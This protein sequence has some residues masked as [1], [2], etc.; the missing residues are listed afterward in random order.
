AERGANGDVDHACLR[1]AVGDA[2]ELGTH[3]RDLRRAGAEP[4]SARV[5]AVVVHEQHVDLGAAQRV[6]HG[7]GTVGGEIVLSLL[8]VVATQQRHGVR[9]HRVGHGPPDVA[10]ERVVAPVGGARPGHPDDAFGQLPRQLV[11]HELHGALVA[12]QRHQL[13]AHAQHD[14]GHHVDRLLGVV[15]PRLLDALTVV[16]L[17]PPARLRLVHRPVVVRGAGLTCD[18][19]PARDGEDVRPRAI[20]EHDDEGRPRL[21]PRDERCQRR[22][23]CPPRQVVLLWF[24]SVLEQLH[25][26]LGGDDAEHVAVEMGVGD[27]GLD[28]IEHAVGRALRGER[29]AHGLPVLD[30]PRPRV[31]HRG[32]RVDDDRGER[33]R[34]RDDVDE[35]VVADADVRDGAGS[36]HA[37]PPT[38]DRARAFG[39]G[40]VVTGPYPCG[41]AASRYLDA[42]NDR[43]VI[44]DGAFG[45]YMQA[46]GLTADDF[47]GPELEGCT[48]NLVLT[49]PD[50]IA[51]MH[52]AF[53]A[54]GVDVIETATFG[55]FVVP[56]GEYGIADR[57]HEINL[58]AARL[59]REVASGHGGF[60]AGSIGP[61]TKFA[62]LGQIRFAELR[63]AYEVQCRGLLEGGVDLL[64]IETQFDLLG[65]KAAVAGARRAMR[66]TGREVPVQA[67]VTV[68]LTGRMVPGTEIAAAL[69]TI[70]ALRV[71]VVGLNCATGPAEMTEH[72][73]HLSQHARMPIS[74]IPNAGLPSVVDGAMHYDL[75]PE[76]LAEYHARFI[77]E[78]G[79]QVVGGCCGTTPEHLRAVVERCRDLTPRARE[80]VHEPGAA[81]IYSFTPFDQDITY[82]TI[83]ERTNANGSKR[84]REAMLAGDW[85]TCVQ[86]AREQEKE[87]A[88]V[89]DV[90]VDY[91]GRDGTADMDEIAQRFATQATV[92]LVL[93]STEPQVMEAGLQWLGGRAILNSAN[94]E[95]GD[96]PGS[97]LDRVFTLARDYGAAVIC[98]LID[99]QGQAR[100]VEWKLRVAHRIHDLAVHRYGLEA[101]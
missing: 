64:L 47:G 10:H 28:G 41:M 6:E 99:E 72:L 98:L 40:A 34:R 83:G 3:Q 75:T 8:L 2:V 16:T 48:D 33:A 25:A 50:L 21:P 15:L 44:Y 58:R 65:L 53:F 81:S 80:P 85:D 69:C 95:D 55:A 31:L 100:D 57:A 71:D 67:Q 82:L 9:R 11:A 7:L 49:R 32:R 30:V 68:E 37:S 97:R 5:V 73:R 76:Q 84:F 42:I 17:R 24:G 91:V 43:V 38:P 60:V 23:R 87:G 79:V 62:S 51:E 96:A 61:G 89:L 86:M 90:C 92:P 88:H 77:T 12:R 101:G 20:R 46:K 45:T 29:P 27:Q 74:C 14:V 59:A 70:D 13:G 56:L 94:L 4:R 63:D 39:F 1:R 54:V 66:A 19:A 22:Q 93:D 36:F 52:E 26:V 35:V 18:R 78:L